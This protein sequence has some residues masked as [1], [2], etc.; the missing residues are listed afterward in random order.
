MCED[1]TTMGG[2][3]C[4]IC[5]H[6]IFDPRTH[7]PCGKMFCL[8]CIKKSKDCT[9]KQPFVVNNLAAVPKYIEEILGG[10]KFECIACKDQIERRLLHAHYLQCPKVF[11]SCECGDKIKPKEYTKHIAICTK[12]TVNCHAATADPISC[13]WKGRVGEKND[14]Q[15]TCGPLL[16]VVQLR[17]M[18][19]LI[20]T[21]NDE[22]KMMSGE[23]AQL[24]QKVAELESAL[25]TAP[26]S[27]VMKHAIE[28]KKSKN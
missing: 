7:I 25:R 23:N 3:I 2:L 9:C 11:Y 6:L 16:V 26:L 19:W 17:T 28:N 27:A 18:D 8:D 10:K 22:I 15:K 24:K 12:I 5:N 13:N 20:K 21:K 1:P 14:H 4:E